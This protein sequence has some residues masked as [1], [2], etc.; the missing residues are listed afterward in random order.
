MFDPA[1]PAK[2]LPFIE[3]MRGNITRTATITPAEIDVVTEQVLVPLFNNNG[4]PITAA[5]HDNG[6]TL[7]IT[8]PDANSTTES[9]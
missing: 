1:D 9:L 6:W 3:R 7:T 8:Y 4:V 5:R 2:A